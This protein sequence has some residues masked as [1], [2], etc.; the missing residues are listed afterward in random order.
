MC[1]IAARGAGPCHRRSH[2]GA[3]TEIRATTNTL[4][5]EAAWFDPISVTRNIESA[6]P[7]HEASMRFERGQTPK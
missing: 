3:E 4:L 5:L 1:V 2:G 6:W 7:T